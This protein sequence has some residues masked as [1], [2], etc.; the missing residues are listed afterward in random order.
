MIVNINKMIKI[1][2]NIIFILILH[3]KTILLLMI[4][5]LKIKYMKKLMMNLFAL[6]IQNLKILIVIVAKKKN[7]H[8]I[9]KVRLN[10][11]SFKILLIKKKN[12]I[13]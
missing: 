3:H 1:N 10:R 5:N 7:L 2:K 11:K 4:L 12:L 9:L 13:N 8:L 6:E